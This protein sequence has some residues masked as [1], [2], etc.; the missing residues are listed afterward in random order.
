MIYHVFSAYE[1]TDPEVVR[2]VHLAQ[3]SW[4][5]LPWVEKPARDA[6]MPRLF[7]EEGKALPYLRDVFDF[8]VSNLQPGEIVIHTNSDIH[9]RSDACI[10]VACT[11]QGMDALYCFRRDFPRLDAP[12]HDEDFVKGHD[13]SGHDMT[14]FRAGWW[15]A[16][17]VKM[18]DMLV[19][20]E[21][22]DPCLRILI[23]Q[24]NPGGHT[25]LNDLIAHERHG[26]YWENPA[27][28]Y[29]LKGQKL[30][31]A[32]AKAFM[33]AHGVNPRQHGIP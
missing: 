7:H 31:L 30:N 3:Q 21:A 29:R 6:D 27:N 28:R 32:L 17:R 16:H 24:T 20:R 23:D 10:Q 33:L 2:R 5:R 25:R 1:P 4:K 26:S 12:L 11:L 19:G 9:V 8:A 18:P 13:Y 15:Q 14:A 22:W